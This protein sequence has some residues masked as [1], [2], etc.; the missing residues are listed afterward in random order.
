MEKKMKVKERKI[1]TM[2]RI[3]G[4]IITAL[5]AVIGI[6]TFGLFL[7]T[8]DYYRS[9]VSIEDFVGNEGYKVEK[10]GDGIY[11]DGYGTKDAIIF[12]PGAKVEYTAYLPLCVLLAEQGVDCFLVEMPFHLSVLG[13]N[14]A[15]KIMEEYTYENW[16]LAGHSLG[17]AMAADYVAENTEMFTGLIL[18]AAYPTKLLESEDLKVLSV[19]GNKDEILNQEKIEASIELVPKQYTEI[20]LEGANHAGFADYGP[21]EGDG[22]ETLERKKQQEMTVDSIMK[23]IQTNLEGTGETDDAFVEDF[24]EECESK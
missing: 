4:V 5:I 17:G 19:Y 20:K 7:Y 21:Q 3:T 9:E 24:H 6:G 11:V 18:L 2:K 16:Y 8:S 10:F 1:N 23:M 12:Y 22:K 15:G 13:V 14:K